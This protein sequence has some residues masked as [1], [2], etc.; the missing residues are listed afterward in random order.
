MLCFLCKIYERL[1]GVTRHQVSCREKHKVPDKTQEGVPGESDTRVLFIERE[2]DGQKVGRGGQVWRRLHGSSVQLL[3]RAVAIPEPLTVSQ[4]PPLSQSDA[5]VSCLMLS[6]Q[7]VWRSVKTNRKRRWCPP[8]TPLFFFLRVLSLIIDAS[9]CWVQGWILQLERKH[10]H[11]KKSYRKKKTLF[12]GTPTMHLWMPC[13]AWSG[14]ADPQRVSE[15]LLHHLGAFGTLTIA[16]AAPLLPINP[17]PAPNARIPHRTQT[18][19][20]LRLFSISNKKKKDFV[21]FGTSWAF[22]LLQRLV[23]FLEEMAGL[24]WQKQWSISESWWCR[25]VQLSMYDDVTSS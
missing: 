7:F 11:T 19:P 10:T 1:L 21:F 6:T 25:S 3:R 17:L 14:D 15:G 23:K 20:R 4:P 2:R 9:L 5:E 16:P 12:H 8:S 18:S 22:T 13:Y 24:D